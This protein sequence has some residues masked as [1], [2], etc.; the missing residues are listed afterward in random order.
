VQL[1]V[2]GAIAD[3]QFELIPSGGATASA[4]NN[5]WGGTA[6][7]ASAFTAVGA[8]PLPSNSRDAAA[9][10]TLSPGA[11][12]V[13]TTGVANV[14]GESVVEIYDTEAATSTA[15][16][17]NLSTRAT[18]ATAGEKLFAGFV[19]TGNQPKQMLVR[20]IGPGLAQF[21]VP[22][23]LADPQLAVI[24]LG[25]SAAVA[26]NNDW[27]GSAALTAAFTATGAFA[28]ATSSRDAALL[29]TLAPGGY[30]AEVSGVGT[31]TG[32]VLVEVYEV[33]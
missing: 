29:V 8:F 3:P 16:L 21:G 26:S 30:T 12:T 14:G 25:G 9:L 31:A 17:I 1:G 10:V 13:R 18:L 2:A 20:A 32:A 23:T 4:A 15:R 11:Y 33:P 5:D 6:A 24:P 27:G 22:G 28:V 19:V 7:L